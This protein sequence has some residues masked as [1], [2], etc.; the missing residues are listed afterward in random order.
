MV[1]KGEDGEPAAVPGLLLRSETD[2]R[3]FTESIR[4]REMRRAH[5]STMQRLTADF[6]A[7]FE[8]GLL[9]DQNCQ[10]ELD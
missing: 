1:A 3:R 8:L 7:D 5:K 2:V 4:R 9:A 6:D 10:V